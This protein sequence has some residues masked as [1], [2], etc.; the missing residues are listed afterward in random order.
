[1]STALPPARP[2]QQRRHVGGELSPT[3]L[4]EG[5]AEAV[6]SLRCLIRWQGDNSV[7]SGIAGADRANSERYVVQARANADGFTLI[8][9]LVI[10]LIIGLL[11]SIAFPV[12]LN[13]RE[14]SWRSAVN[15]DLRNAA[16]SMESGSASLGAYPDQALFSAV[17]SHDVNLLVVQPPPFGSRYCMTATHISLP[18]ETWMLDSIEGVMRA[19]DCT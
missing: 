13:Q 18:G 2:D 6:P 5:A 14:R 19:G 7:L 1:V 17:T 4:R 9:L 10:G 16:V 8:E 11:A 15:S 3:Q 12:Y